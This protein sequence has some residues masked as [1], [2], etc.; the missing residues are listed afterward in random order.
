[1]QLKARAPEGV[2]VICALSLVGGITNVIEPDATY[3]GVEIPYRYFG[4]FSSHNEV[5]VWLWQ[6]LTR[7]DIVLSR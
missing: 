2:R 5:V 1:M 6:Q 3:R 7:S 4:I